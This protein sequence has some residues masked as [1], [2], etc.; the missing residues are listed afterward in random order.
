MSRI[1]II[2]DSQLVRDMIRDLVAS[3]G[4]E[5][6]IADTAEQ[7]WRVLKQTRPDL[8]VL[9]LLLPDLHGVDFCKMMRRQPQTREIPIIMIT[10]YDTNKVRGFQ[11]GADDYVMK[12]IDPD[13]FI[14]RIRAVLRRSQ[15]ARSAPP[16]A[17]PAAAIAAGPAVEKAG[18]TGLSGRA[19]LAQVLFEPHLLPSGAVLP[20]L[21]GGFLLA[22]LAL[23]GLGLL[24]ASSAQAKPLLVASATLAIWG[25]ALAALV[26]S[27]SLAG[28]GLQWGESSGMLS[29]AGAPL[30]LKFS[31]AC[32]VA[33]ITTLSPFHFTASPLLFMQEGA[34]WLARLDL[35]EL[36]SA[37]LLWL[38]VLKHRGGTKTA[39]T[40]AS[41]AVWLFVQGL[42]A[43]LG[44]LNAG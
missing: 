33:H 3:H 5:V 19:A 25:V 37:G 43:G 11:A 18:T 31:A 7:G 16:S 22:L 12:P 8:V 26:V 10:S 17:A 29:L 21:T 41:G 9:D 2:D 30:I 32:V 6:V 27:A 4:Y 34:P 39:A 1:L 44:H 13:E 23:L 14:E 36:W 38:L 35:F 15:A 20:N 42:A 28:L 24:G 40:V